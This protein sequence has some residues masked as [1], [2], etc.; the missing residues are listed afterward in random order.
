LTL[1]LS[2]SS[3]PA[4][5]ELWL[6]H[7]TGACAREQ[8]AGGHHRFGSAGARGPGAGDHLAPVHAAAAARRGRRVRVLVRAP[9]EEERG[10]EARTLARL[11]G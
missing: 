2:R 7:H 5:K 3:L 4:L 10:F 9:D 11:A 1:P 8:G 6:G